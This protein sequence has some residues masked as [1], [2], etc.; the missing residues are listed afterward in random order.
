[1]DRVASHASAGWSDPELVDAG[2]RVIGAPAATIYHGAMHVFARGP[3]NALYHWGHGDTWQWEAIAGRFTGV[4]DVAGVG[5]QLQTVGRG[6]DGDLHSIWYDPVT[7]LWNS[8][9]QGVQVTD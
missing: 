8:E 2:H 1:P 3:D 5:D 6:A 7:G 4:P 9:D